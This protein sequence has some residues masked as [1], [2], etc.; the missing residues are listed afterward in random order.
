MAATHH[1]I[2][3]GNVTRELPIRA[4]KAGIRMAYFNILNDWEITEA[5]ANALAPKIPF[6]T[7]VLVM[8]EGKAQGLL[9]EMGRI[10]KLPIAVVRKVRKPNMEGEVL[11]FPY[12][13]ASSTVAQCLYLD[14]ETAA[15]IRRKHVAVVDDVISTGETE[16]ALRAVF[17][18]PSVQAKF[19]RTMAVF[20]EGNPRPDVISLGHLPLY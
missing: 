19:N 9:T 6:G 7:E 20:V 13:S 2:R 1:E 11:E 4:G 8:A 12:Q 18:H 14:E 15:L 10:A 16:R 5:A 17:K 3:I